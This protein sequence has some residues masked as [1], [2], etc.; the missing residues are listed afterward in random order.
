MALTIGEFARRLGVTRRAVRHYEHLGLLS[1]GAIEPRTGYR[2]YGPTQLLRGLQIE[3]F[4]AAGVDLATICAILDNPTIATD[5]LTRHRAVLADRVAQTRAQLA[6]TDALIAQLHPLATPTIVDVPAHH[7]L[8]TQTITTPDALERSIRRGIQQVARTARV[9][10][11]TCCRSFSARFPRYDHHQPFT[12]TV[13][14]HLDTPMPASTLRPAER[15]LSLTWTGPIAHLHLA[16][17]IVLDDA[18]TRGITT[19]G[20][21]IEHYHDLSATRTDVAV[22]ITRS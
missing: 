9:R 14:G 8:T 13:A 15:H 22:P 1:P 6:T 10:H 16:H 18:H 20:T 4:K 5:V 3:Q 17:Q 11:G 19:D 12:V 7:A 21:I 2:T